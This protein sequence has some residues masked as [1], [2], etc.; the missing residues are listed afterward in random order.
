[1]TRY[2]V[3]R[4]IQSIF[5]LLGISLIAFVIPRLAP[6]GPAAVSEDPRLGREYMEQQR[7]EFGLDRPIPVQYMQWLWQALHG[8]F[9]RSFIDRRPVLEKIGDRAPNTLL[10]A[11]TSLVLGLLGIPL[12]V[13]AALHR[14]RFFD[15]A[16]RIVTVFGNALPHWWLGLVILLI[17]VRTGHWLPL[18]GLS[19]PGD[20]SLPDRLHHLLLPALLGAIGGWL[21]FSRFMRSEFLEVF[22]LDYVRTARAKGLQERAVVVRHALRNALIPIVTILG[23][24]LA[25]LLSGSVLFENI[26]S[27]PGMGKLGVDSA[28]QRDYPVLI[29]LVLISSTLIIV[30][31][32]LADIAYGFVD[33]RVKLR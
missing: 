17:S 2:I 12:G 9:G 11:G 1:V 4:I 5:L 32:L 23:G 3:R 19:T 10:L 26:F 30:G 6:G 14:G 31:Q 16:L 22:G 21:G 28:F 7:R 25:S 33:P 8:N 29:A 13:V 20:G 15:N 24:S 18:G 27:W